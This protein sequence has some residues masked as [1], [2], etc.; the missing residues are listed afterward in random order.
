MP[1][2]FVILNMGSMFYGLEAD[3]MKNFYKAKIFYCLV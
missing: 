3:M 1:A 2:F